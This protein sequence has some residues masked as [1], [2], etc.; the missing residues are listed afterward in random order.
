[1]KT[2]QII[3]ISISVLFLSATLFLASCAEKS[4]EQVTPTYNVDEQRI[5]T[6][7]ESTEMA[8]LMRS[9]G[10]KIVNGESTELRG[11]YEVGDT[12]MIA[13]SG[14]D[15]L[16]VA[17]GLPFQN[18]KFKFTRGS[19][20]ELVIHY[21]SLDGSDEGISVDSKVEGVGDDFTVSA[22]MQ[23]TVR[24]I[25]TRFHLIIT[26]NKGSEKKGW[27]FAIIMK[28]KDGDGLNEKLIKNGTYRIFRGNGSE[29][30]ISPSTERRSFPE[31]RIFA[32]NIFDIR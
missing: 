8:D 6:S 2:P 7:T 27:E 31:N 4:K 13:V 28:A 32:K 29:K 10:L 24:G 5:E 12:K 23:S 17:D 15:Q 22:N 30:E 19:K 21:T 20:G 9:K 26:G 1:M 14:E 25:K 16:M 11:E 3:N 18:Y